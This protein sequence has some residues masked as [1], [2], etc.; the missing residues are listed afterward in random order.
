MGP[1]ALGKQIQNG[2]HKLIGLYRVYGWEYQLPNEMGI[3]TS[4]NYYHSLVKSAE[5]KNLSLHLVSK[6]TLG[7]TFTNTSA[8]FLLKTGKLNS[9]NESGYWS[10]NLNANSKTFTTK[11]WIFFLEPLLQ[12]Q[13]YNATVQGPL[14]ANNKGPFHTDI[15]S[16]VFQTRAGL[17]VTGNKAGL[18]WYY[19]FRTKEGAQMKKGE[20]WGTIGLTFRF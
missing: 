7:N 10:A 16:F 17:M 6:A 8:G 18:R 12:Y 19:T 3:N 4:A 11:E 14:F 15:S 1:G 9:E 5:H 13:F 2:W 20:H